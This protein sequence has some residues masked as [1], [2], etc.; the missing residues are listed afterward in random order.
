MIVLLV[1][2]CP[3]CYSD[4]KEDVNITR[5]HYQT[6]RI[7][8]N[9]IA[10]Q[11]DPKE[12]FEHK[13]NY[14][15]SLIGSLNTSVYQVNATY[16]QLHNDVDMLYEEVVTLQTSNITQ[17]SGVYEDTLVKASTFIALIHV[18]Q[19]VM[20]RT[21]NELYASQ[22]LLEQINGVIL[23]E[24]MLSTETII[25]NT[26]LANNSLE[27]ANSH[28]NVLAEQTNNVTLLA[29]NALQE[30]NISLSVATILVKLY[31]NSQQQVIN[32]EGLVL[33]LTNQ[34]TQLYGEFGMLN[35]SIMETEVLLAMISNDLPTL[36]S[37][38]YINKLMNKSSLLHQY[39]DNLN[40][41]V[42]NQTEIFNALNMTL[43]SLRV[44]YD[45]IENLL[46][47]TVQSINQYHFQLGQAYIDAQ[48]A[49][50]TSQQCISEANHILSLLKD[51]NNSI[52]ILKDQADR[53]L[54]SVSLIQSIAN[55][56][57][58]AVQNA[59][60]RLQDAASSLTEARPLAE[61]VSL[62]AQQLNK[63][64]TIN[65]LVHNDISF[66]NRLLLN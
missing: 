55:L 50:I 43:V 40:I 3:A 48:S 9:T 4:L 19:E 38:D 29:I 13:Q 33:T 12:T 66:P 54:Q 34:V 57:V 60:S 46:N 49:N 44:Q 31:N 53:A 42:N 41:E 20:N 5:T 24:I 25:Y 15:L 2:A 21:T 47:L 51:F 63:V 27:E 28:V 45:K 39:S 6:T 62:T 59:S 36:P 61:N 56:T 14:A 10:E 18:A 17:I 23:P 52:T 35:I 65:V 7:T 1:V 26:S 11:N 32:L 16:G 8:V 64:S 58:I 37:E 30:A 22:S